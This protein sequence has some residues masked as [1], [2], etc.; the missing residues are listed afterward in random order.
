MR[1]T[2][3]ILALCLGLIAL[4]SSA[5]TA[6]PYVEVRGEASAKLTPNKIEV[7]ITLSEE[8]SKGKYSIELQEGQLSAAL[9]SIGVDAKESLALR[10][11]SS[12]TQKRKGTYQYKNLLLTL[13]SPEELSELFTEVANTNIANVSLYRAINTNTEAVRDS[14]RIEAL[15]SAKAT[16]E[17][18]AGALDQSIG[19]AIQIEDYSSGGDAYNYS[20]FS[21]LRSAKMDEAS[22]GALPTDLELQQI[23]ITQTLSVRFKLNE[24]EVVCNN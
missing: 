21:M 4:Q 20:N 14:L 24:S 17:K 5:Q 12:T 23:N 16:A 3:N 10:S 1:L 2:K 19:S 7:N 18:L 15:K 6:T 11:Q 22:A 8:P 13:S 9:K